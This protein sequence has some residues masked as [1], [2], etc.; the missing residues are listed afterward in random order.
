MRGNTDCD[1]L[2]PNCWWLD[3]N[4]VLSVLE[5]KVQRRKYSV[6]RVTVSVRHPLLQGGMDFLDLEIHDSRSIWRSS[7]G[8]FYGG[9]GWNGEQLSV[10]SAINATVSFQPL[11]LMQLSAQATAMYPCQERMSTSDSGNDILSASQALWDPTIELLDWLS[12]YSGSSQNTVTHCLTTRICSGK[13]VIRWFCCCVNI[14][15]K[16]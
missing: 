2:L 5:S 4:W 12:G 9:P 10:I 1:M 13:R 7:P 14:V 8:S 15:Y 3:A 11:F 16:T 6:W